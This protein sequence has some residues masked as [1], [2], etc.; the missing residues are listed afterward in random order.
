TSIDEIAESALA[1][2][3]QVQPR[4]PYHLVGTCMGAVVAYELAQRLVAAGETVGLL[5]LIEPRP[6]AQVVK[7]DAPLPSGPGSVLR[8]IGGRLR[9]YWRTFQGLSGRERLAYLK[10]R[11]A[12]VIEMI[13]SRDLFRGNRTELSLA[14]VRQ[15]NLLAVHAYQPREYRGPVT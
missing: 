12:M 10:S 15:A 2:I 4:G 13:T 1:E 5:A 6:P 3:R 8:F 11:A 9:L 7:H 14:I